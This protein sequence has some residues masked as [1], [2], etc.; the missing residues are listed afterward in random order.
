MPAL[1]TAMLTWP[2]CSTDRVHGGV[3]GARVADV[4]DRTVRSALEGV[5]LLEHHVDRVL[6]E[7]PDGDV[8]SGL[9]EGVGAGAADAGGPARDDG[10]LAAESVVVH[11]FLPS[12][13]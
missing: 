9:R 13:P 8:G 4:D 3:D 11:L 7:V 12:W 10:N 5:E 2:R 6:V 1:Q